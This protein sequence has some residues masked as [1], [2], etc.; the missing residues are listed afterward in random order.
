MPPCGPC[1]LI[2]RH[3][4][5][6]P[7]SLDARAYSVRSE[8]H[9]PSRMRRSAA[10]YYTCA[11][12]SSFMSSWAPPLLDAARGLATSSC[13]HHRDA[14]RYRRLTAPMAVPSAAE[15][16]RT[17]CT[18]IPSYSKARHAWSLVDA[19]RGR[20]VDAALRPFPGGTLLVLAPGVC[21]PIVIRPLAI[22]I[23]RSAAAAVSR[24]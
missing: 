15:L 10:A 6:V 23:G 13:R 22:A 9:V 19:C 2:P 4:S 12:R 5:R 18:R 3:D 11:A 16:P 20:H 21:H 17:A 24:V 1:A 14:P 7:A 8:S